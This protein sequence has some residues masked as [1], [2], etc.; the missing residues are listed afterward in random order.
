M[1]GFGSELRRVRWIGA[2]VI[3]IAIAAVAAC[4]G[5]SGNNA[6]TV[7]QTVAATATVQ[8]STESIAPSGE[9]VATAATSADLKVCGAPNGLETRGMPFVK[10]FRGFKNTLGTNTS[11]TVNAKELTEQLY[12]LTTIGAT[13]GF[14]D[15]SEAINE[16][17]LEVRQATRNLVQGAQSVIHNLAK[18]ESLQINPS[19]YTDLMITFAS[20]IRAC[21]DAGYTVSWYQAVQ[22]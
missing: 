17:S 5:N 19:E 13:A 15:G 1:V 2:P 21:K 6:T 4:G 18:G 16:A 10:S 20:T 22:Q 14:T 9:G 3:G 7:T 12:A 8:T 11:Q